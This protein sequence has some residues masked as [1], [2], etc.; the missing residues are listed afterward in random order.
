MLAAMVPVGQDVWFYK[1][2]GPKTTVDTVADRFESFV[3]SVDYDDAGPVL[4]TLPADWKIGGERAFRFATIDVPVMA[5]DGEGG[6]PL[7]ISISKLSKQDDFDSMIAMNVNRWREQLGL[8]PSG[9]ARAGAATIDVAA[10]DDPSIWVDLLGDASAGMPPMMS[11]GLAGGFSGGDQIEPAMPKQATSSSPDQSK[12][13][14]RAGVAKQNEAESKSPV[15]FEIPDGWRAGRTSSMRLASF[16]VGPE[17]SAAEMTVIPAG[18]DLRLNVERWIEQIRGEKPSEAIVDQAISDGR[19]M[20]VD[21][22]DAQRFYLSGDDESGTAIDAT[23]VNLD[24]GFSLFVKMTGPAATVSD[25]RDRIGA[26]LDSMKIN[27]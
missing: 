7:D 15:N 24:D 23:V 5:G 9:Q 10:A 11:G 17:G 26:F 14:P 20:T 2:T 3:K 18:G 13:E 4:D 21:G 25:Q 22:R 16:N 6:K 27:L 1:L 8:P 12:P 19:A